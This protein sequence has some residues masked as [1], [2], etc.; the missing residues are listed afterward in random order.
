MGLT[1]IPE[2]HVSRAL[3]VSFAVKSKQ[4]IATIQPLPARFGLNPEYYLIW[5]DFV[6]AAIDVLLILVPQAL[7]F[8]AASV[9]LTIVESSQCLPTSIM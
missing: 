2:N 3:C 8:S 6:V 1:V 4:E 9:V 7:S 5:D